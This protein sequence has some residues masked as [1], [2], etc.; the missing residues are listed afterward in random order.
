MTKIKKERTIDDSTLA[1]L[2][3]TTAPPREDTTGLH[4]TKVGPGYVLT[5]QGPEASDL[6]LA[7]LK[8]VEAIFDKAEN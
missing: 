8:F 5:I 7:V 3:E 1:E 2:L 6:T 4:V